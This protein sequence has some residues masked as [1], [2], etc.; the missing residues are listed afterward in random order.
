MSDPKVADLLKRA[1]ELGQTDEAKARELI[2][3]FKVRSFKRLAEVLSKNAGA[4]QRV[5]RAGKIHSEGPRGF[6]FGPVWLSSIKSK[7]G[8]ALS[9]S[10]LPKLVKTAESKGVAAGDLNQEQ[11]VAAL[12]KV[13]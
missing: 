9:P 3:K 6:K 4:K 1:A 7:S 10:N 2:K 11:L 13:L 5:R 8:I 12:A